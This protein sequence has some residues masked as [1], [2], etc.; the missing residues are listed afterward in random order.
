MP[1]AVEVE[2][3]VTSPPQPP[4][5]LGRLNPPSGLDPRVKLYEDRIFNPLQYPYRSS[6]Y[7][8]D[9]YTDVG[10]Y[11]NMGLLPSVI[12]SGG[13]R[14]EPTLGGNQQVIG[15]YPSSLN[16]SNSNISPVNIR[17]RGNFSIP[18]QVGVLFKIFGNNNKKIL[19]LFGRKKFANYYDRWEYY[20]MYDGVKLYVHNA[21]S[22]SDAELGSND[23]VYIDGIED[24][25][26]VTMYEHDFPSYVPYV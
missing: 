14:S 4:M 10:R 5:D 22:S 13:W 2:V 8:D 11:P 16:I 21:N 26:R 25:Y 6:Q 9:V 20:T 17:T 19:P 15:N 1:R 7:Y 18:Q 12:G 3:Q 24:K 23:N